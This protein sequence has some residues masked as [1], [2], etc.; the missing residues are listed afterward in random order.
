V[1]V[2]RGTLPRTVLAAAS[3]VAFD[4]VS[5]HTRTS[6]VVSK[7]AVAEGDRVKKG[8][9]LLVID[10][11]D[12]EAERAKSE[13]A[14]A[15]AEVVALQAMASNEA[16]EASV[17]AAEAAI[18]E[19]EADVQRSAAALSL[20]KKQHDRM[21]KL[22]EQKAIDEALV[23]E[24]KEKLSAAEA[25]NAATAAKV[26]TSKANLTRTKAGVRLAEADVQA[27]KLRVAAA[28]ADLRRSQTR[29]SFREIRAPIDGVVLA[30]QVEADM[31]L[32][33]DDGRSLLTLA[34]TNVLTAVA[35]VAENDAALVK[36]GAAATVT[37]R[38]LGGASPFSG[39]VSR[40]PYAIDPATHTV[41][42]FITISNRD[43]ILKPG[44]FAQARIVVGEIPD[45]LFLPASA[46]IQWADTPQMKMKAE[47][48]RVVDGRA[49]IVRVK[50]GYSNGEQIEIREGLTAGSEVL[51]GVHFGNPADGDPVEVI[52]ATRK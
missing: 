49:A 42:A 30:R 33:P 13:A 21:H 22:F 8:D 10:I 14:L 37:I 3:L 4:P 6:G 50:A 39:K 38:A 46:V 16:A 52:P 26:K 2:Q 9:V 25:D 40:V 47:C 29:E 34:Q 41:S 32:K 44:M 1:K 17:V 20:A 24:Q 45:V 48:V 15:Q 11:P 5:I 51:D 36:R 23:D 43:E 19:S 27:A 18:Q 12:L 28:K 31:F 35:A 7:V